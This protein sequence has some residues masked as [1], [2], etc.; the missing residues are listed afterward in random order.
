MSEGC[1]TQ[2]H[3][4]PNRKTRFGEGEVNFGDCEIL[5]I[6]KDVRRKYEP[7]TNEEYRMLNL[8]IRLLHFLINLLAFVRFP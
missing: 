7:S 5:S 1:H 2:P 6:T 8:L 3:P 4:S